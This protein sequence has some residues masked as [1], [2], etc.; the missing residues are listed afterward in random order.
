MPTIPAD[1]VAS[2][3]SEA[4]DAT[5]LAAIRDV[6]RWRHRQIWGTA[7]L[8]IGLAAV[9]L[10]FTPAGYTAKA[11]LLLDTRR[12]PAATDANVDAP[13]D[14]TVVES[15]LET[16]KSDKIASDALDKLQLW[17]NEQFA[18]KLGLLHGLLGWLGVDTGAED[19]LN[20]RQLVL[21][22][23]NRAKQIT[24][25]GRSFLVEISFT[26][27][28]P[29]L[30]ASAA[31][32]LASA[33]IDD[34]FQAK[35]ANAQRAGNWM[36]DRLKNLREQANT[37][38]QAVEDFKTKDYGAAAREI[39]AGES[40]AASIARS[41]VALKT[42]EAHAQ[43]YKTVYEAFLSRTAQALQQQTSPLTDARIVTEASAPLKPSTPRPVLVLT[44]A[45]LLGGSLGFA[46]ALG[47]EQLG[48]WVRSHE[49]LEA[50]G[51][52][53][54]GTLP[55]LP[56]RHL[57]SAQAQPRPSFL[58]EN[59]EALRNIKLALDDLCSASQSC[60]IAIVSA[61]EGEGRSTVA[62]N[63]AAL[64][65]ESAPTL[66]MD[67]DLHNSWLT[68][69]LGQNTTTSSEALAPSLPVVH[70]SYGFDF[71]PAPDIS[72]GVHPS[73]V[74]TSAR[75]RDVMA[76]AAQAYRYRVVDLPSLQ[77]VDARAAA[78]LFDCFLLVVECGSTRTVDIERA[79]SRSKA[80][81]DRLLGAL[82]NKAK[83]K[84]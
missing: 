12:V 63:L 21:A 73:L 26:S 22:N 83:T 51:I 68:R 13:V 8:A 48:Q 56:G 6:F 4:N 78:A 11:A 54:L 80:V 61:R 3:R 5:S 72:S 15:Q 35:T 69:K 75:S 53:P 47:R 36:L 52:W 67:W 34:L 14:M 74:L 38:D 33:Y 58:A 65:A 70:D 7:A 81:A 29:K 25:S 28:D 84:E 43:A 44:L 37:A 40:A 31:N 50:R 49:T 45:G 30:S 27:R 76:Q 16:L 64:L 79:L 32:A 18:G 77:H 20:A 9:W 23:F 66:L 46:L 1:R 41:R 2:V 82:L 62:Y 24:R 39:A 55:V 60:C 42:L 10:A 59:G 17:D 71:L 57:L 19:H